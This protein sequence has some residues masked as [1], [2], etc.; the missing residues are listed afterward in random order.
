MVER[1]NKYIANGVDSLC[2]F[3]FSLFLLVGPTSHNISTGG[4]FQESNV[5]SIG[6]CTEGHTIKWPIQ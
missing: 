3:C 1:F 5:L 2:D 4:K 6:K